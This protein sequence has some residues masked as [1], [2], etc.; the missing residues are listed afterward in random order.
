MS[1]PTQAEI[2]KLDEMM[3]NIMQSSIGSMFRQLI[4]PVDN[5]GME[6]TKQPSSMNSPPPA[7]KLHDFGGSDFKRLAERSRQNRL[8]LQVQQKQQQQYEYLKTAYTTEDRHTIPSSSPSPPPSSN[9]NKIA[10]MMDTNHNNDKKLV[11]NDW[12]CTQECIY[13]TDGSEETI[14]QKFNNG[15]PTETLHYVNYPDGTIKQI[16]K[17]TIVPSS[18]VGSS[19]SSLSQESSSEK[20]PIRR[21]WHRI[22]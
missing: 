16:K 19:L 18:S 2:D 14:Y 11:D 1:K 5:G 4:E 10:P 21:F 13:R 12:K 7:L 17:P 6:V 15:V 9:N 20:G 3:A 8:S 22:F